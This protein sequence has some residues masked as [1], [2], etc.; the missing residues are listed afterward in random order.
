MDIYKIGNLDTAAKI[1]SRRRDPLPC[2]YNH[3][4]KLVLKLS[5]TKKKSYFQKY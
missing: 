4:W 2:F 3:E 1:P 5:E